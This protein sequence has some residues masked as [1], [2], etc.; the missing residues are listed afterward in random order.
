MDIEGAEE[1]V[2]TELGSKL[3]LANQLS[4]EYHGTTNHQK[5]NS[6]NRIKAILTKYRFEVAIESKDISGV[7]P[8]EVKNAVNPSLAII[9][10]KWIHT[11]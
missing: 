8:P 4:I 7:F 3:R 2:V 10:A 1:Q 6:L 5:V 9:R 11:S